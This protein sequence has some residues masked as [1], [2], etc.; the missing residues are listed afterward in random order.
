MYGVVV[1]HVIYGV[2]VF[3]VIN[4]VDVFQVINGVDVV[5]AAVYGVEV[6]HAATPVNV[7]LVIAPVPSTAVTVKIK[8]LVGLVPP[9]SVP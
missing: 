2:D 3:Q 9:R 6:D 8:S 7:E 4:G 5:H 1:F